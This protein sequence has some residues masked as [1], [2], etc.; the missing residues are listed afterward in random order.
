VLE[1]WGLEEAAALRGETRR[2]VEVIESG[3]TREGAER[4]ARK[5]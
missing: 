2:G 5:D 3:E 4:F 1:Q